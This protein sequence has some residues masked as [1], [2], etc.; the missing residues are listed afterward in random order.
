MHKEGV[1][2]DSPRHSVKRPQWIKIATLPMLDHKMA[3]PTQCR[4]IRPRV[5]KPT[6]PSP[7]SMLFPIT[8]ISPCFLDA[9]SMLSSVQTSLE[10]SSTFTSTSPKVQIM[11]PLS[12]HQMV[13][14]MR[15]TII[16][17]VAILA[18]AE[19]MWHIFHFSLHG[20]TP[21]VYHLQ[22]HLQG[23]NQVYFDPD[24]GLPDALERAAN[25]RSMLDAFYIVSELLCKFDSVI[26]HSIQANQ[27]YDAAKDV[28]YQDFPSYFTCKPK[29]MTWTPRRKG[30]PI[31][32][33]YI[34]GTRAGGC[35]YLHLLLTHVKGPQS[36][37]HLCTV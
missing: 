27:Q 21:N 2:K 9:M 29:E 26:L 8:L 14:Q 24:Q 25:R 19:V 34:C 22:L 13:L 31:G 20:S 17:I 36:E 18:L 7:L 12:S 1:Q 16:R 35:F 30:Y 3:S 6:S 37:Q 33:I 11:Q 4:D 32:R 5:N 28:L 10:A 15:F 23:E